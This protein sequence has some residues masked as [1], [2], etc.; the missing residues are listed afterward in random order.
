MGGRIARSVRALT[1]P[2]TALGRGES[3]QAPRVHVKKA[4][5]VG[6]ALEHASGLLHQRAAALHVRETELAQ[7][8][9]RLCDVVDSTPALIY[10]KG[11]NGNFLLSNK[12]YERLIGADA[13]KV[14]VTT[15]NLSSAPYD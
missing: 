6:E 2:A 11:L 13:S 8:H 3:V 10:L 7:A 9:A 14:K 4:A 15:E 5:E 12:T 1:A